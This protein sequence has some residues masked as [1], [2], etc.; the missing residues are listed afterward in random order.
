MDGGADFDRGCVSQTDI[1]QLGAGADHRRPTI[2][3]AAPS[4]SGFPGKARST[5]TAMASTL[6]GTTSGQ[7]KLA[8]TDQAGLAA[9]AYLH[10]ATMMTAAAPALN[11]RAVRSSTAQVRRCCRLEGSFVI[12][13][14]PV[15]AAAEKAAAE[16]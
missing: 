16:D 7:T 2:A 13:L 15:K 9:G 8:I 10:N 14:S 4:A 6:T 3:P 12:L 11:A 5:G 1:A